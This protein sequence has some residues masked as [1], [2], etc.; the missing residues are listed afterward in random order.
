MDD[1]GNQMYKWGLPVLLSTHG[2]KYITF[3]NKR[4]RICDYTGCLNNTQQRLCRKHH[5]VVKS[6]S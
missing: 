2:K 5:Y 1:Q 6:D 3:N 4:T